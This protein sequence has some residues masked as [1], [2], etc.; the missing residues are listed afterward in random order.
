MHWHLCIHLYSTFN[1]F[2]CFPWER[3]VY[4][5]L[6][7]LVISCFCW[8]FFILSALWSLSLSVMFYSLVIW[9]CSSCFTIPW[10]TVVPH[11]KLLCLT[12]FFLIKHLQ[13]HFTISTSLRSL[14]HM[15]QNYTFRLELALR[16]GLSWYFATQVWARMLCPWARHFTLAPLDPGVQI[17][18]GLIWEGNILFLWRTGESFTATL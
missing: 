14:A 7:T 12:C 10:C 4:H 17:D 6:K 16:L 3:V 18:I 1:I 5:L 13:Y 15:D 8:V 9:F 11:V 2:C